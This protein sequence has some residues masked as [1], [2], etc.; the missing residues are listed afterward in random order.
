M[1]NDRHFLKYLDLCIT[2]DRQIMEHADQGLG[3]ENSGSS[4]NLK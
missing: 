2:S 1:S 3:L 4:I